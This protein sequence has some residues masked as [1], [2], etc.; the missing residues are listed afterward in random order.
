[1]LT[2]PKGIFVCCDRW[3]RR[4]ISEGGFN[5]INVLRTAFTL[6]GPKSVR[7]QTSSQYLFTLLGS[8]GAKAARRTLM[9]LSRG[10]GKS[11]EKVL[12]HFSPEKLIQN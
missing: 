2:E 9:K 4:G 3:K 11:S 1:M 12:R 6:V 5:F 7:I 10:G 8:T